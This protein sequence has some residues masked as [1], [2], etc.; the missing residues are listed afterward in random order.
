MKIKFLGIFI[1]ISIFFIVYKSYSDL[2]ICYQEE[3]NK[4]CGDWN[5]YGFDMTYLGCPVQ[6]DYMVRICTIT[7]PDCKEGTPVTRL[8]TR[9]WQINWDTNCYIQTIMF[10][11]WPNNF[12][13]INYVQFGILFSQASSKMAEQAFENY[14]NSS[15]STTKAAYQCPG[16]PPNCSNPIINDKCEADVYYSNFTCQ[17]ICYY[18]KQSE[19][20]GQGPGVI[21]MIHPCDSQNSTCCTHYVKF[22]KCGDQIY[23][24]TLIEGEGLCT[25]AIPPSENPCFEIPGYT[26]YTSKECTTICQ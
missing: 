6:V 25:G 14:Y 20:S 24:T 26:V 4:Y 19:T 7:R 23:K 1:I 8:E 3:Q 18:F 2:D 12:S 5:T 22:C 16:T 9:I 17:Y 10:P 21:T 15:D 13:D 11:G